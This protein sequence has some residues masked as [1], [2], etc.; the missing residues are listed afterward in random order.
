MGT[1]GSFGFRVNGEDKLMYNH[2]D[3]Y[4]SGLG[5][6]LLA[7]L[8][9]INMATLKKKVA[10]LTAVD[11][12]KARPTAA[13]KAKCRKA[14]TVNLG[15]AEQ[16]ENDWYCLIRNAQGDL[17]K[18]LEVGFFDEG[19]TFVLDS[20]FCEWAYIVNL[21]T[22]KLEV[23]EGFNEGFRVPGG[24][25]KPKFPNG[26]YANDMS[27]SDNARRIASG[28]EPYFGVHLVAEFPL[29]KLPAQ[30]TFLKKTE[31]VRS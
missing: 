7:F 29:D 28:E 27:D 22:G 19:N 1:R 13:Q 11:N 21:D 18:L 12:D 5:L 9:G 16:S 25:W 31:S 24:K 4:P 8:K 20:I 2:S 15:V 17:G 26:R 6:D 3:S 14:G 30:Q 23:Y 10:K